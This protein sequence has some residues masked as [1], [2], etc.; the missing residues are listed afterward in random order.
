M[1]TVPNFPD[2]IVRRNKYTSY[3]DEETGLSVPDALPDGRLH[4]HEPPPATRGGG[5]SA[6]IPARQRYLSIEPF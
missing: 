4:A 3:G 2:Y 6:F 1:R 5:Q